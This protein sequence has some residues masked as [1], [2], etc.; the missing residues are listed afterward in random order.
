MAL[1]DT[2][3]IVVDRGGSPK[4]CAAK[5]IQTNTKAGDYLCINRGGNTRKLDVANVDSLADSDWVLVGKGTTAYKAT[6]AEVKGFFGGSPGWTDVAINAVDSLI[7]E[8]IERISGGNNILC[9]TNPLP[10][11]GCLIYSTDHGTTWRRHATAGSQ[12]NDGWEDTFFA[13]GVFMACKTQMGRP[14]GEIIWST[15]ANNWNY[16][17]VSLPI[18]GSWTGITYS[19]DFSGR[20]LCIGTAGTSG[21]VWVF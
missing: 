7:D 9:G 12:H 6:G 18:N 20:W 2:D 21:R 11:S 16:P 10:E 15:N 8:G 19:P 14:Q 4:K 5:D 17:T 3:W 13:D 1:T